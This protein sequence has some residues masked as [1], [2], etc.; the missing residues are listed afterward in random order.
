MK[1]TN[2]YLLATVI[3]VVLSSCDIWEHNVIPSS[4]V[5]SEDFT[6]SD[7]ESINASHA[8]DVIITF[9]N[10]DESIEIEANENLHQYIEVKKENNTLSIGLRNDIRV[11]GSPTLKA[12]VTTKSI[13]NFYGSGASKFQLNNLCDSRQ[14]HYPLIRSQHV[15]RRIGCC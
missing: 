14:C 2:Y 11:T 12:Y 15:F 9:S 6:I 5:T 13:S 1:T 7:Y 3:A 8:F 4:N 10:D